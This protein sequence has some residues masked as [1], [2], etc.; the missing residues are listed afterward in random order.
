M[1]SQ[2]FYP[3]LPIFLHRYICHICDISQLCLFY[4]VSWMSLHFDSLKPRH[5]NWCFV[6]F[7]QKGRNRCIH[8]WTNLKAKLQFGESLHILN[9]FFL[10]MLSLLWHLIQIWFLCK[11]ENFAILHMSFSEQQWTAFQNICILQNQFCK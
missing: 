8:F 4:L 9:A 3:N 1:V 11:R 6:C 2:T 5:V 7:G 10:V